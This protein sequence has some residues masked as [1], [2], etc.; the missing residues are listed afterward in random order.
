MIDDRTIALGRRRADRC[1]RRAT[2][3]TVLQ[4]SAEQV[5]GLRAS[6]ARTCYG[7]AGRWWGLFE[8]SQAGRAPTVAILGYREEKRVNITDDLRY[9]SRAAE[10]QI[11]TPMGS[12]HWPTL[13]N[14]SFLPVSS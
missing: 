3:E 11:Q 13:M 2:I 5:G 4:L 12:G 9:Y 1:G 8:E 14:P 6:A 10:I 7:S